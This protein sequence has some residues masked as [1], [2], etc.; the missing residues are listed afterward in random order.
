MLLE[1]TD[2]SAELVVRQ[3]GALHDEIPCPTFDEIRVAGDAPQERLLFGF[4]AHRIANG[5]A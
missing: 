3:T 4:Q 2:H 5:R 1:E